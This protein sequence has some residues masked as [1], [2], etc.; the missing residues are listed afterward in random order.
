MLET[1]RKSWS[2]IKFYNPS[3]DKSGF[4]NNSVASKTKYHGRFSQ[5]IKHRHVTFWTSPD[6]ELIKQVILHSTDPLSRWKNGNHWQRKL[7]NKFNSREFARLHGCSTAELYWKG[8]DV[9][10][11]NFDALPSCYV[12]R[13][14]AG[15][16]CQLVFLM[17]NGINL[18]DK[19]KYEK[20][21]LLK[22]L[23]K[24][25]KE[26]KYLEFLIEEFVKT[27]DKEYKIPVDYKFYTFNGKIAVIERIERL[28]AKSG[29]VSYYDEDWNVIDNLSVA[30]YEIGASQSPPD[31]LKEMAEQ[32]RRLSLSYQIFVRIDFYATDKG[33]VFGEF[34]PTPG[35]ADFLTF[36][37]DKI[38]NDYWDKFCKGMI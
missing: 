33:A 28:S 31:C 32:A 13:P 3:K 5:R 14:T 35:C 12:I 10:T 30:K 26:N 19:K 11:I 27:E 21:D 9:H 4:S 34:T 38:F 6:T 1:I 22:V 2:K 20:K 17:A 24:A 36:K 8:R 7:S 37:A 29:L 16:S 25:V 18:L 23:A 15:H